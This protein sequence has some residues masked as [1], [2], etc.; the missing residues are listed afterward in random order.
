MIIEVDEYKKQIPGYDPEKSEEFHS[1]SAKLA[2]KEFDTCLKSGKYK[3]IV[4]MAGGTASGKTEFAQSY[5]GKKDQLVYDGTLK[6]FNGFDIKVRNINRFTKNTAKIKVVLIIPRDIDQAFEI[7]LTRERKMKD[8]VFFETHKKSTETVA[9]ILMG[10]KYRV[11]IY[12]S[13]LDSDIKKLR[14]KRLKIIS[15]TKIAKFLIAY[16][17][18]INSMESI[19]L[20]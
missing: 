6:H 15:R 17:D 7:F 8:E 16:S 5:F 14:Y 12:V 2:N 10:T 20:Q 9:Q 19:H 11:E 1:E 18:L 3:R 4:F 13:E